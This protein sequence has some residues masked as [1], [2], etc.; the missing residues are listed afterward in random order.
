MV[1]QLFDMQ[2]LLHV[3]SYCAKLETCMYYLLGIYL[4]RTATARIPWLP[5]RNYNLEIGIPQ[6]IIFLSSPV[7]LFHV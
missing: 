5:G 3:L 6:K 2:F 7:Q 4:C 1:L